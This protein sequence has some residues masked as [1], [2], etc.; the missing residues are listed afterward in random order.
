SH[1][2]QEQTRLW[3]I[4][5]WKMTDLSIKVQNYSVLSEEDELSIRMCWTDLVAGGRQMWQQAT[6]TEIIEVNPLVNGEEAGLN[7]ELE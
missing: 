2:S 1:L 6:H 3:M 7:L 5:N 4:W